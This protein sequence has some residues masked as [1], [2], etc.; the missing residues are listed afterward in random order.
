M[1]S[2]STVMTNCSADAIIPRT[3]EASPPRRRTRPRVSGPVSIS[4]YDPWSDPEDNHLGS[5]SIS[6]RPRLVVS[7]WSTDS[8]PVPRVDLPSVIIHRRPETV[9][10][11][12]HTKVKQPMPSVPHSPTK[13]F[14][15]ATSGSP[16]SEKLS[17]K[18]RYNDSMIMLRIPCDIPYKDM[19]E[20][21]YNKFVGQEGMPL[22]DSFKI[23]Y[24]QPVHTNTQANEASDGSNGVSSE[25]F[26]EHVV[27]SQADWENVT[28]SIEGFKLTLRITDKDSSI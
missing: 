26:Q 22:S 9:L 10:T 14:N 27:A 28:I 6:V 13:S 19:R 15:S 21:L 24:L 1:N 3:P 12:N 2:V 18:A 11:Y 16:P 5:F 23:T 17:I 8:F 25:S 20:R 4:E 7:N